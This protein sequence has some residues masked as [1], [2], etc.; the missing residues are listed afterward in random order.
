MN[1]Y[2][3]IGSAEV[4]V[5][6]GSWWDD[7][8]IR[9]KRPRINEGGFNSAGKWQHNTVE[10]VE[11]IN[12][13]RRTYYSAGETPSSGRWAKLKYAGII[14][15]RAAGTPRGIWVIGSCCEERGGLD[16]IIIFIICSIYLT[17]CR[18][19]SASRCF[20][21]CCLGCFPDKNM[22]DAR[23]RVVTSAQAMAAANDSEL[24]D[25]LYLQPPCFPLATVLLSGRQ[26][27]RS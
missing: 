11:R 16:K 19:A 14:R 5:K 6:G 26:Q 3:D 27:Q 4:C 18:E 12:K 23:R 15:T 17:V 21:N 10:D 25:D 20:G 7:V 22:I 24:V 8:I 13:C 9:E 1:W 2:T